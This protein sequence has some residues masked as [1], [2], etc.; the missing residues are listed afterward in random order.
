MQD[1]AGCRVVVDNMFDQDRVIDEL[2]ARWQDALVHDRRIKP[3][4]GYRAVHLVVNIKQH[5][6]EIQV[7]TYLQHSWAS[8]T[9]KLSD[10]VHP[11]VKYGGGPE[12]LQR[13]LTT[14]S[15]ACAEFERVELLSAQLLTRFENLPMERTEIDEKF[16]KFF[17]QDDNLA[18]LA[19]MVQE[20]GGVANFLEKAKQDLKEVRGDINAMLK[21]LREE[22]NIH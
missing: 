7:R 20:Q 11:D 10:V 4:H 18:Y 14:I 19:K 16:T 21:E 2:T 12:A 1:I 13:D 22:Y 15:R 9:E 17:E 8:V 6:V 3:S 5:P